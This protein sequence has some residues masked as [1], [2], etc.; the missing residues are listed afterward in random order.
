MIL[1]QSQN[2]HFDPISANRSQVLKGLPLASFSRRACAFAIDIIIPIVICGL[3]M[4]PEFLRSIKAPG[5]VKIEINPF[6]GWQL[7]SLPL[8]FGLWTYF[9]HGQTL[10]KKLLKIRVISLTHEHLSLWHSIE[11]SLGYAAS[12]LEGGFGF[13]QYFI[14]PNRQTVHDRIAETIVIKVEKPAA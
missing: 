5:D 10:G 7:L 4:L 9:G 8:Y 11:R 6:H 14:H 2:M 1:R 12:F 13:L 3:F